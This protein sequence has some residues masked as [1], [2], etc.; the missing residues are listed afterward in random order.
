LQ[1][2][3]PKYEIS[4]GATSHTSYTHTYFERA[5]HPQLPPTEMD[6]T[7][8]STRAIRTSQPAR[9][10]IPPVAA[11]PM[12]QWSG[13][14]ASATEP[15]HLCSHESQ[16]PH[17]DARDIVTTKP[18]PLCPIAALEWR[19]SARCVS[20][21]AQLTPPAYL[22][23]LN[24]M[25]QRLAAD[26]ESAASWTEFVE[27]FRGRQGDFHPQ[28]KRDKLLPLPQP[29]VRARTDARTNPSVQRATQLRR[30]LARVYAVSTQNQ[31]TTSVP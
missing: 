16:P 23:N 4:K 5:H 7:P 29:P 22:D 21:P 2:E 6:S 18:I 20:K 31:I 17:E 1:F 11:A 24:A 30:V 25:V 28:V 19:P 15:S 10:E 3:T 27:N 9:S 8:D 12:A 26:Y 14:Q 13:S